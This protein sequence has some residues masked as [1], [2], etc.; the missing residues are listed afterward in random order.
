MRRI[1]FSLAGLLLVIGVLTSC[2]PEPGSATGDMTCASAFGNYQCLNVHYGPYPL[3]T[4]QILRSAGGDPRPKPVIIIVHGGAWTTGN[5]DVSTG[6][7]NGPLSSDA[8]DQT[9]ALRLVGRD[10]ALMAI[11]Y[12]LASVNDPTTKVPAAV[13]DVKAA[14]KWVKTNGASLG[15]DT[16]RIALWGHSAG[17]NLVTL[18]ASS[19][20]LDPTWEPAGNT[21]KSSAVSAMISFAGIYDFNAAISYPGSVLTDSVN[22]GAATFLRC[23]RFGAFIPGSLPD[24]TDLPA[25]WA[26]PRNLV[27]LGF[28][29]MQHVM[30]VTSHGNGPGDGV[31]SRDQSDLYSTTLLQSGYTADNAPGGPSLPGRTLSS[32][33]NALNGGVAGHGSFDNCDGAVDAFLTKY[34]NYST[35][36]LPN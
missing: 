36:A 19:V 2:A 20:N 30:L 3:N 31:V 18:A 32:C 15:L 24:C 6:N 7:N 27:N 4:A 23:N 5:F 25:T 28:N 17:G 14:V 22:Q 34:F 1:T 8:N 35:P 16:Q 10:F 21:N 12:R 9:N 33:D 13:V 29:Q 26:S 11:N